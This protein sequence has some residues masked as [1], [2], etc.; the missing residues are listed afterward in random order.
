MSKRGDIAAGP[1]ASGASEPARPDRGAPAQPGDRSRRHRRCR[2]RG[3]GPPPAARPR[4][5]DHLDLSGRAD[6]RRGRPARRRDRGPPSRRRRHADRGADV[7]SARA[8]VDRLR[9]WCRADRRARA[10]RHGPRDD[11]CRGLP[12]RTWRHVPAR[13][14]AHRLRRRAGSRGLV[15]RDLHDGGR[16]Y[17]GRRLVRAGAA[18]RSA[19]RRHRV[20][21]GA[22][23]VRAGRGGRARTAGGPPAGG[24]RGAHR[25]GG[26]SRAALRQAAETLARR[27]R[28]D[29]HRMP[30]AGGVP[31]SLGHRAR[32]RGHGHGSRRCCVG[33]AVAACRAH[34]RDVGDPG[35]GPLRASRRAAS[36]RR[37]CPALD[38][39]PRDHH[40]RRGARR[41]HGR[42]VAPHL[43]R[44]RPGRRGALRGGDAQRRLSGAADDRGPHH[45]RGSD[46]VGARFDGRGAGGPAPDQRSVHGD[47]DS[48]RGARSLVVLARRSRRPGGGGLDPRRPGRAG[49]VGR[50]GALEVDHPAGRRGLRRR[51]PDGRLARIRLR[52]RSRTLGGGRGDTARRAGRLG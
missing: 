48:Q 6:P 1:F 8:C 27:R 28:A 34:G 45:R 3:G 35:G 42:Q 26:A 29:R 50:P 25:G 44:R 33:G 51:S 46:V 21:A 18:S 24:R 12:A 20:V 13:G 32:R 31:R 52:R 37:G 23:H 39:R 16:G 14:P 4:E 22:G 7:L 19:R 10:H 2:H 30:G 11:S 36:A 15:L 5:R 43:S 17:R 49:A 40:P 9:W 47:P 41:L 38:A